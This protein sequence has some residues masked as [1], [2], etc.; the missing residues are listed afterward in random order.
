MP[1]GRPTKYREALC[2]QV[3]ELGKEGK[4]LA[5]IGLELD[6]S[7]QTIH[8]WRDEKPEFSD[9]IKQAQFHAEAWYFKTFKE[10]AMGS[11]D[12][13]M[14]TP[15]IFSS[16]NQLPDVFRDKQEHNVTG[17]LEVF[18]IDFNGFDG[19]EDAD[20]STEEG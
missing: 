19:E 15:L 20:G 11:I 3:I 14:A 7:R 9:A 12:G 18:E 17:K 10:M 2:A 4:G 6:L 8:R 13:A 5:E 16:K 1:A